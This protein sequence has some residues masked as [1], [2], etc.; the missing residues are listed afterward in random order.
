MKFFQQVDGAPGKDPPETPEATQARLEKER[1]CRERYIRARRYLLD[2]GRVK[3]EVWV[4]NDIETVD[5]GR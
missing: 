2:E 3:H 5:G 4:E 1:E